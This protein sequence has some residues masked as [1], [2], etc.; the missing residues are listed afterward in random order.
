MTYRVFGEPFHQCPFS[1][2]CTLGKLF[3]RTKRHTNPSLFPSPTPPPPPVNDVAEWKRRTH[4]L[5]AKRCEF[6]VASLPCLTLLEPNE[7]LSHSLALYMYISRESLRSPQ[8]PSYAILSC[9]LPFCYVNSAL[10][11]PW[12]MPLLNSNI[13][14]LLRIAM[15]YPR[16]RTFAWSLRLVPLLLNFC[17]CI[18]RARTRKLADGSSKRI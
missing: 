15:Y 12:C 3:E 17:W 18:A 9:K 7:I 16:L 14:G 13:F 4:N 8:H 2:I 5:P 11:C 10:L 1:H 6:S